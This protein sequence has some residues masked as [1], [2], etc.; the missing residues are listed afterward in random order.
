VLTISQVADDARVT[1][2][3]ARH[4]HRMNDPDGNRADRALQR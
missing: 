2:R 1:V 4:D 3:T